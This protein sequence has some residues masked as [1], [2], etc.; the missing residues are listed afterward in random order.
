MFFG[1]WY[2]AIHIN[3]VRCGF[4]RDGDVE[5][6]LSRQGAEASVNNRKRASSLPIDHQGAPPP[7]RDSKFPHFLAPDINGSGFIG[8]VAATKAGTITRLSIL[9]WASGER[10]ATLERL[11]TDWAV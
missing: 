2:S 6:V 3:M 9:R 5:L 10:R 8:V 7:A 11:A 1:L 4:T